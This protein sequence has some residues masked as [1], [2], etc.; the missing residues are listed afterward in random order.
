MTNGDISADALRGIVEMAPIEIA[1]LKALKQKIYAQPKPD[2]ENKKE[3]MWKAKL[4]QADIPQIYWDKVFH[5]FCNDDRAKAITE[6]YVSMIDEAYDEGMGVLFAGKHGTGKTMLSCIVLKSALKNGYTVRYLDTPK[7]ID[8]IMAGFGDRQIK[9]RLSTIVAGTE[10][11]VI[12]DFGKEYKGV[13]DKLAPMIQL[14]FDRIL[15]L[16]IGKG[17]VTIGTTNHNSNSIRKAYGD[18]VCSI[19]LGHMQLIPVVGED[20]RV[21]RG[22]K[23]GKRLMEG[24]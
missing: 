24:L 8:N 5:N 9:D 19:F 18:S 2:A 4:L 11:L 16:R 1:E 13:G 6:R 7:I 17:K 20:Y 15:R 10:F 12:D 14:E 21:H 23:F 3:F 22:E